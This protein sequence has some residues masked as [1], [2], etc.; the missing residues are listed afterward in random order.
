MRK[1]LFT[2]LALACASTASAATITIGTADDSTDFKGVRVRYAVD[3]NDG[4][5]DGGLAVLGSV[6]MSNGAGFTNPALNSPNEFEAYCVD[7]LGPIFNSGV[8]PGDRPT[9]GTFQATDRLMSSWS[10]SNPLGV[11]GAAS[12]AAWLY[13]EYNPIIQGQS[14]AI[15]VGEAADANQSALDGVDAD[16]ARTALQMAIWNVLYDSDTTVSSGSFRAQN[17]GGNDVVTLSNTLLLGLPSDTST[18]NAAYIQLTENC[19]DFTGAAKS[20]Q[21]FM[22][23]LPTVSTVPEPSAALLLAFGLAAVVAGKARRV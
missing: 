8:N 7:I 1:I 14:G 23:P 12:R 5:T 9:G 13:N 3:F 2:A 20:C 19:T 6:V 10:A 22:G 18:S 4:T 17:F 11:A 21:D 15:S 16:L